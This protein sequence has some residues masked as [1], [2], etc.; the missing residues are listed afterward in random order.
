MTDILVSYRPI[1]VIRSGHTR[2]EDTPIQPVFAPDCKGR[3]EVF[4]EF[5][6]GLR[7]I[8]LYS[9]IYLVYHLHKMLTF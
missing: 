7:D 9:H 4:P 3:V 8:E 1:G 5:A 2:P 6:E